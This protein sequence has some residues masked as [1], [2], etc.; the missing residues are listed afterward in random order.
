MLLTRG[1]WVSVFACAIACSSSAETSPPV[2]GNVVET[3]AV[4]AET[5]SP[6]TSVADSSTTDSGPCGKRDQPC[7]GGT[8]CESGV[9]CTALP[10]GDKYCLCDTSLCDR[11]GYVCDGNTSVGCGPTAPGSCY[12]PQTKKTCPVDQPCN[13]AT[14]TC[15]GCN[16]SDL[17]YGKADGSFLGCAP[18]TAQWCRKGTDG[19]MK[20]V[21]E[22]CGL[23][24]VG[25]SRQGCC[26]GEGQM[27]CSPPS[28][29]CASGLSCAGDK[30]TK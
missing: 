13:P 2:D 30:C 15:G 11:F 29:A 27:C 6:E 28:A 7:C 21:N 16:A 20:Q 3:D 5:S 12:V 10:T 23:S 26:G 14:G 1:L 24:C 19:C 18:Y 8:T 4:V 17:C 22:T 9:V 25:G